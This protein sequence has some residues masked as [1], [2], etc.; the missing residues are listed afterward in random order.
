MKSLK[1][2]DSINEF[3][4][5][6]DVLINDQWKIE[7]Q[8]LKE[9]V[10]V[11]K[12]HFLFKSMKEDFENKNISIF[13]LKDEEVIT[14]LD[15]L[16]L[17]RRTLNNISNQFVDLSKIIILMEYPL[18][19]GN[20]MRV[21]YIILIERLVIVLEF[22]MFN[23]DERRSEERFTK[24]LQESIAYRQIITNSVEQSLNIVN[25]VMIYKPE[26]DRKSNESLESNL[27]YNFQEVIT[28]S[29]FIATKI[30]EQNRL[31]ALNQF[32]LLEKHR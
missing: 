12:N 6:S 20:H 3:Y 22:G 32:I 18:I 23:Q 7:K 9:R 11:Y 15:T 25:Y 10:E 8:L 31:S 4:R 19:Y 16:I 13:Q 21:D 2:F 30:S 29:K 24:K 26:Y 1:K 27:A 5:F 14:W 17:L 28:L